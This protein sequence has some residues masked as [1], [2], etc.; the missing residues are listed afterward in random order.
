MNFQSM[1]MTNKEFFTQA[2]RWKDSSSVRTAAEWWA[3]FQEV[4]IREIFYNGVCRVPGLGKFII[5]EFESSYKKSMNAKGKTVTY[6]V[7]A[8][9]KPVFIPED[10]FINDINMSGVTKSYRKRLKNKKLIQRDFERELRAE[11][12]NVDATLEEMMIARRKKSKENFQ[13]LLQSK[14]EKKEEA[15]K[16]NGMR[17]NGSVPVIQMDLDGN[18]IARFPS[19]REAERQTGIDKTHISCACS[20]LYGRKTAKGYK[21]KYAAKEESESDKSNEGETCNAKS[22][23]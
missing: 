17:V 5:Q 23:G 20:G 15:V 10:D 8:R 14:R 11:A 19:I 22:R 18:E 12:L 13:K 4:I 9:I 21:W 6:Y 7:P 2:C 3:A 1:M 16:R